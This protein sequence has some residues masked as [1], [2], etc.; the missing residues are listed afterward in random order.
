MKRPASRG[1]TIAAILSRHFMPLYPQHPADPAPETASAWGVFK[2]PDAA[3]GLVP[4]EAFST[5][6]GLWIFGQPAVSAPLHPKPKAPT[7]PDKL[8]DNVR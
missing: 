6:E 7:M 2:Y 5:A 8:S 4:G 1:S 3:P